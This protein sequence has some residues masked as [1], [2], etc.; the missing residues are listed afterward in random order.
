MLATSTTPV[1]SVIYQHAEESANLRHKRSALVAAPHVKLRDL[2]R[3]DE[4]L[5]AHLDGLAV[6]GEF[7]WEQCETALE[8]PGVGEVF[9]ATVRVIEDKNPGGLEKLVALVEAVPELQRGFV[10]A[11]GWVSAPFLQG[12]IKNLLVSNQPFRRQVGVSACAMH[13]VDPSAALV[14]AIND[15]DASLR[16]RG[17][18]AA[19]ETGRRD[20]LGEC[21]KALADGDACR[22]YHAARSAVLLGERGEAIDVLKDIALHAGP[23]RLPA[24]RVVLKVLD[25]SLSSQL[26]K[27][28]AP[29]PGNLRL[30]I[31]GAGIAGDP[32]YVPWLIKQMEDPKFARL[33][34]ESFSFI[35]GLDLAR[36]DLTQTQPEDFES[37]PN[38]DPDDLDVAMNPDDNLPWPDPVRIKAWWAANMSRFSAGGGYFMGEPASLQNCRLVLREGYQRQRVAASEYLSLLQPGLPLFPTSAPAWRQLRWLNKME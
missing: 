38:D 30:L 34:G 32:H 15:A 37:G 10:S 27:T 13:Q 21:L 17:L 14:A 4:R 26:L 35:T 8:E 19:G 28:L 22:R 36:L 11:F 7:G 1:R 12:T 3:H 20:L 5:A 24:L 25:A 29:A 31:Q 16:V 23:F 18:R 33:A 2:G 6:A 9:T